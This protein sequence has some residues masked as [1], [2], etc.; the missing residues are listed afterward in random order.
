MNSHVLYLAHGSYRV[1]AAREHVKSLAGSG[2]RVLLV[3]PA[4]ESWAEAVAELETLDNVEIVQLTPDKRGSLLK[5]AKKF[6]L[7]RTGPAASVDTVVAGDAQALPTAWM[8]TKRRPDVTLRLE[9]YASDGRVA[10]AA[11]IAVITPW[12]PSSNNPYAGAFVKAATRSVADKFDRVSIIHT[13]DWSGPADAALND[14]IKITTDRLQ[15][16]RDLIPVLDTPEGTLLRVPVPLV[17]RKNYS[18]WVTAQETALRK[19]LPGGRIK[20]PVIHAHAGIYG[21]VLAMRLAQ[22]DARIVVTEHAT[23][24]NKVFSQ[25]AARALYHDVLVR[26]DAFL[27]VS[28]YLRDQ[29]AA[30]FPDVAD[31]LRVVPNVID[32][33]SFSTGCDYSSELRKWLY[34]GRLVKHKGVGELLEA[35]ALVAEKDPQVTLTM[36]GS[37]AMEEALLIRAA[38]LGLA[39]RFTVLPPVTP[40]EV[41]GLMHRHDLLVHASKIE[42]FGMT[43]VEAVAAGLPVLVT[44]SFGPEE[45]LS[46]IET[47]AGSM[48]EVSDDPQVIAN[49]YW[50]LRARAAELD[51]PAARRVLEQRYGAPAV[52]QQLM[53]V[54][55]DRP[56]APSAVKAPGSPEADVA[57]A[58]EPQAPGLSAPLGSAEPETSAGPLA[59]GAERVGRAV[60]LALAPPKPRRIADFANHLL[61]RGVHVT[62][63]TANSSAWQRTGLDPRVAMVSIEQGEKRLLIPRGE[64]FVV[65]KAPRALLGRARRTA[66]KRRTAITSELAVAA[67]QRMHSRA[68][69]AFHKNVFNRGY[70]EVRPQLL[71][72]IARRKALPELRLDLTD[73]VF[74]CDINS[75]VTGWKWAKSYPNLTVT[76]NLDRTIYATPKA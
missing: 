46:G 9:P 35:F 59:Q 24:L 26:A 55:L 2:D 34:V 12:Y 67:T 72:R 14:A 18:P 73:H 17:H 48:M 6:V 31:K 65:Y 64:R 20:A 57:A 29:I 52:A 1:R 56:S 30:E 70:R 7:A 50:E 8:L 10:E 75:T 3:V 11:D 43:I 25:P 28:T 53:D 40:D 38:D 44:R 19:A 16:N 49:A 4:T 71:A 37:G 5:A 68:A 15:D 62:V 76:T 33:D 36:V 66:R 27:C 32:F 22:P 47:L 74:V 23:F 60:L 63:V 61:E 39:D 21:G 41:N 54:Y 13:E 45:T 51:L 69:N 58:E 42:T